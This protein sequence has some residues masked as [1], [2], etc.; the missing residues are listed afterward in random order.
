MYKK[1]TTIINGQEFSIE[2]GKIGKQASGAAWVTFGQSVVSVT[3][4]AD[5]KTRD[6]IDFVP[7]TVDYQEFAYAAGRV[8]GNYF[9]REMGRPSENETL[10]SRLIDRP[11]RP[12]IGKGWTYETQVIANVF[13]IDRVNDTDVMA[14]T[15]ASAALC[16]SD[17]PFNGPLAGVRVGRVDGN[18]II[19]P[20]FAQREDS[21]MDIIVAGSRQAVV[22]VEG[23]CK[24]LAEEEVL[25]AIWFGHRNLIPLLTIQEE[26]MNICGK[27][28]RAALESPLT[29]DFIDKIKPIVIS[30]LQEALN[31]KDKLIRYE[32]VRQTKLLAV[33][34]LGEEYAD[35]TDIVKAAVDELQS[36]KM[37]ED[38]LSSGR[39]VDGRDLT[40]VRPIN[41]ETGLLPRAHGSALFTRGETQSIVTTT[42][43]TGGDEQR[44]ESFSAGD[45]TRHFMLHYNFPPYS[46]NEVKRLSGPGRREIGHGA[47]ARRALEKILPSKEE[48]PYTVRVVSEITESNGSSSMATVCGGSLSLMDAGVPVKS[49]VAGVAMGLI[50][51]GER[52]AVLTDILG[53]E[54]HLGDMDFKV[55]GTADGIT[56][57]QMDIKISGITKDIMNKALLQAR[58]ARLHILTEM[59][60]AIAAPKGEISDFAPRITTLKISIEKIKD[61][62]GPGGKIIRGIQMETGVKIDV[63]DD[64]TVHIAAIDTDS[65]GKAMKI[66]RELTQEVEEGAVYDGKVVKLMD[67]GA[68]VEIM[69]GRDG[70]IHISEIDHTRVRTVSDV[71]KEGDIVKVKV[72]G[73]DD[74]GKVRLSRKAMLPLPEESK[75]PDA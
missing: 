40:T 8:P 34:T 10:T 29:D 61:I 67:F 7:L 48:F 56:A 19:N 9:R 25:E 16:I 62:I 28:K 68:F 17:I 13:S 5:N 27:P 54:D 47:L 38:I 74:R 58:T 71:L 18:L 50:M 65:A 70:L 15:G 42:L 55:A 45:Y 64:G 4:V 72:L 26:L 49:A 52:M 75:H 14:L 23:G 69:P 33:E 57:V 24:N 35:K 2:T 6:G 12:N 60:K 46:V 1:V 11:L 66:I 43:G 44:M 63:E 59:S 36:Q 41:I 30:S 39:R 31:T 3:A 20:T 21:D 32:K 37:R 53:D 22:M 51:E 73:I